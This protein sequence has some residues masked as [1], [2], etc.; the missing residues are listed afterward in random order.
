MY[1]IIAVAFHSALVKRRAVKNIND[2]I[3]NHDNRR[4]S[5]AL[6]EDLMQES[7]PTGQEI[8]QEMRYPNV[9]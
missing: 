9:T 1:G 3:A 6:S 4:L 2:V 5:R 8:H 7:K